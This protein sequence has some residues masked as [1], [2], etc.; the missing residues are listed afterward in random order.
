MKNLNLMQK[1]IMLAI[2]LA[3][4]LP[5]TVLAMTPSWNGRASALEKA[6]DW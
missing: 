6:Q 3:A 5:S 2:A 4:L 1:R